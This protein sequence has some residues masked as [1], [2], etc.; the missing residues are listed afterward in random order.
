L[1]EGSISRNFVIAKS[2]N[3]LGLGRQCP[4]LKAG[5]CVSGLS[6]SQKVAGH[7]RRKSVRASGHAA[8]VFLIRRESCDFPPE[9]LAR[10]RFMYHGA[11]PRQG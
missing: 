6:L 4:P 10:L 8:D 9:L 2:T 5:F 11:G 7:A 1:T 3:F